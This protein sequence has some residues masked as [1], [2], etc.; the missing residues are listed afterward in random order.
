MVPASASARVIGKRTRP[1]SE[2]GRISS[3]QRSCVHQEQGEDGNS[4]ISTAER[5]RTV[6][7]AELCVC[8]APQSA[9]D[10]VLFRGE[11]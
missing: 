3:A 2:G 7:P 11:A 8:V 5:D 4:A 6:G 1:A 10:P 9:A